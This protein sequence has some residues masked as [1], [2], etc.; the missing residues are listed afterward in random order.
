[1]QISD[2]ATR[3]KCRTIKQLKVDKNKLHNNYKELERKRERE[4]ERVYERGRNN[5]TQSATA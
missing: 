4:R 1:M 5:N 2:V 3:K